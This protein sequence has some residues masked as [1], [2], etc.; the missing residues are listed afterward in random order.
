MSGIVELKIAEAPASYPYTLTFQPD[1]VAIDLVQWLAEQS[2]VCSF[3]VSETT[4]GQ[5][6]ASLDT[7][8]YLKCGSHWPVEIE[9]AV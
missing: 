3:E 7:A 9:Q 2:R 1:D 6:R 8:I 5:I 4:P